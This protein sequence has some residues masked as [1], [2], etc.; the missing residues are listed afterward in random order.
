MF[1]STMVQNFKFN[2]VMS[3][4]EFKIFEVPKKVAKKVFNSD[5]LID[6]FTSQVLNFFGLSGSVGFVSYIIC[7]AYL[8]ET[9][10]TPCINYVH[11]R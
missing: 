9:D 7:Y 11:S 8:F 1:C 2:K 10:L 3:R 6:Y 4:S 5:L